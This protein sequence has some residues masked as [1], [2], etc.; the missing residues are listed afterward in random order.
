MCRHAFFEDALEPHDLWVKGDELCPVTLGELEQGIG[1]CFWGVFQPEDIVVS[2]HVFHIVDSILLCQKRLCHSCDLSTVSIGAKKIVEGR[3]FHEFARD[4][5][6][7]AVA[8]GFN[9]LQDM[10]GQHDR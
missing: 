5:H 4:E 8:N 1:R 3:I 7:N 9:L 2:T 6:D 10:C